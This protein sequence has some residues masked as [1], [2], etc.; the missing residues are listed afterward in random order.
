MD[1]PGSHRP[2][3]NRPDHP[4]SSN[5]DDRSDFAV[6]RIICYM[7]RPSALRRFAPERA[8]QS[9]GSKSAVERRRSR[10]DL[11]GC[12]VVKDRVEE[13]IIVPAHIAEQLDRRPIRTNQ[14]YVQV[15]GKIVW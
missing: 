6:R 2:R 9:L 15:S 7:Q 3:R 10:S 11:G 13:V 12:F 1:R 14:R 8:E 5:A 4:N